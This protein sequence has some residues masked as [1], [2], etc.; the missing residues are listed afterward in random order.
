MRHLINQKITAQFLCAESGETLGVYADGSI[1]IGQD[2]GR[3][4]DPEDRP[5]ATAE[6]P[7]W[8]NLDGYVYEE[9]AGCDDLQKAITICGD[10]GFLEDETE[11]LIEEL[12]R[13]Q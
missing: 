4:I 6:C 2:V 12:S 3:E 9:A 13:H 10:D 1:V 11:E 7:G 5:I 8:G